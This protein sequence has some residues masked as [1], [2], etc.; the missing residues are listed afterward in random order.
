MCSGSDDG[1][2]CGEHWCRDEE[3]LRETTEEV[4]VQEEEG[5]DEGDEDVAERREKEV[6][7]AR[8]G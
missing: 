4:G 1:R 3:E 2:G 7:C 5:E 6:A 8:L